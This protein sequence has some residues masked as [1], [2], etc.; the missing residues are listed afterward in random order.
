MNVDFNSCH[1]T[2][3][4]RSIDLMPVTLDKSDIYYGVAIPAMIINVVLVGWKLVKI[5]RKDIHVTNGPLK[6][7]P[8]WRSNE[9]FSSSFRVFFLVSP[10]F[11]CLADSLFDSIYFIKLKT[12]ARMIL[13][14]AWVHV[15]QGG[16]LYLGELIYFFKK[17]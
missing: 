14:P 10:L 13:V 15:V 1:T 4:T 3:R 16:L 11:T 12:V 8:V 17:V 9:K 6:P 2:W 7:K 5:L